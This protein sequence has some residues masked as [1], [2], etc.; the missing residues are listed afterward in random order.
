MGKARRIA[1]GEGEWQEE[2]DTVKSTWSKTGGS[3]KPK[4]GA[5]R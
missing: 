3:W 5:A 4:D 1:V 2:P